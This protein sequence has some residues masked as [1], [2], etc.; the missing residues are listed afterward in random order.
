M[1]NVYSQLVQLLHVSPFV[2][3]VERQTPQWSLKHGGQGLPY[4]SYGYNSCY[5]SLL[6]GL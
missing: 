4:G 1:F 5:L 3:S 2:Q 6:L